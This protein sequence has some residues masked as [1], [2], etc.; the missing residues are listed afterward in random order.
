MRTGELKTVVVAIRRASDAERKILVSIFAA[1]VKRSG[2]QDAGCK[3]ECSTYSSL[4]AARNEDSLRLHTNAIEWGRSSL[5]K[6][7]FPLVPK[8]SYPCMLV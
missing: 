7:S 2:M 3:M 1:E 8:A 5:L 6:G 4:N